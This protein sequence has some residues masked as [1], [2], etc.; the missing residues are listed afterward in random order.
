MAVFNEIIRSPVYLQVA[1]QLREAILSGE[2]APGEPLPTER[3]LS[4]TFGASRASVREALR[5]LEAQGL[6]AGS[7]A[8]APAVVAPEAVSPAR[9]AL[10]AM[11]RL[12]RVELDDLVELRCVLE[13]AALAQAARKPDGDRLAEA[14][15]A[16]EEMSDPDIGIEAFDDADVRF[17]AALV[18]ASGNEAMHLVMRAL[19]DPVFRHLLA[20]L[21]ARRDPRR[22]LRRL[23]REHTA[24]LEAVES[25]E[26]ER[27]A[28]LVDEHI[29]SFYRAYGGE[30][31]EARA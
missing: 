9:D 25:G 19:R 4:E 17:H 20:A 1:E 12:N 27:A 29:R 13:S 6:I 31:A 22:V 11:L 14:R 18:R 15:E 16:L 28:E 24:I 7:G 10:V 8:P 2:L 26:G 3:A 21:R 5:V 30:A 23:V